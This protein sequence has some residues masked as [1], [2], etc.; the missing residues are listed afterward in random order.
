[1]HRT[2]L[3]VI[4]AIVLASA[5]VML[6]MRA[7]EPST[8]PWT[9]LQPAQPIRPAAPTVPDVHDPAVADDAAPERRLATLP[10][11]T[12]ERAT[13]T[14]VTV[15]E[16]FGDARRALPHVEVVLRAGEH[17][18][19]A[20]TDAD[21]IARF[22]LRGGHGQTALAWCGLGPGA[23]FRLDADAP[24][25]I[26]LVVRPRVLVQ[27]SVR[28]AAGQPVADSAIVLLPWPRPGDDQPQPLR[29]ARS[30]TDG[31]FEVALASGGRLGAHHRVLGPS[32]M[33]L[34]TASRDRQEPLPVTTVSLVLLD[35]SPR[36]IGV[37]HDHAGT[38]VADARIEFRSLEAAP[39][40]SEL[41]A[42]PQRVQSD[43]AGRFV[44]TRLAAGRVGYTARARGHGSSSGILTLAPAAAAS[45]QIQLS[46]P[47][48]V[49][50]RVTAAGTA[51]AGATVTAGEP[52]TFAS[53]SV[54]TDDN[55]A[56]TLLDLPAGAVPLLAT[57]RDGRR[58]TATAELDPGRAHEWLAELQDERRANVRGTLFAADGRPLAGWTIVARPR[59]GATG[60]DTTDDDGAFAVACGPGLVDLRAHAPKHVTP[61]F[62]TAVLRA[63]DPDAGP[64]RFVVPADAHGAVTAIVQT[65]QQ[66]P[67]AA[68]IG[69][70][71]H[72]RAEHVRFT[73]RADGTFAMP[74]VPAGT[75]DL[76]FEHPGYASTARRDLT[77][78]AGQTIE[79][80][81]VVLGIGGALFGN[82][83]GPDGSGPADCA[84]TVLV[85][86]QRFVATYG[87]GA[88]RFPTLPAGEHVL[89]V[90]G[91]GLAAA[92]FPITIAPGVDL[93]QDVELRTGVPR[94]VRV[95][96]PP[97]APATVAL[98]IRVAGKPMQWLA[99]GVAQASADGTRVAEFTASM[100]I[101]TYEALAW[102]AGG[103]EARATIG[104]GAGDDSVVVMQLAK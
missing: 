75:I 70:W 79:L 92:S 81:V 69:C 21:G 40:G 51:V 64:I 28:T 76:L 87:G 95:H 99:T 71:H 32:A 74:R 1:M 6:A 65:A 96:A 30:R 4:I 90:Q 102:A 83:R 18:V 103:F 41:R 56:F 7:A 97:G 16:A 11:A 26:E 9:P 45:L 43:A 39:S 48:T 78:T 38:P 12:D 47:C 3:L 91:V 19:H 66:Q 10:D 23:Q 62:A 20:R 88:Y 37:V 89:L 8:I 15:L 82:V 13:S 52:G 73:A 36:V 77:I 50:G 104:F 31:S 72:E 63:V 85:G 67:V 53:R 58:A 5:G 94:V 25:T 27:G 35:Q 86:S 22:E 2:W 100:A 55:G 101:G 80:G 59:S 84:L 68:T 33:F 14:A 29:V 17:E 54:T 24:A 44:A 98:A 49:T 46:A 93:Q 60:R 34:V 61:D 42:V 57:D